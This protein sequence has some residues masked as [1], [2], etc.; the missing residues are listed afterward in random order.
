MFPGIMLQNAV[1]WRWSDVNPPIICPL[2]ALVPHQML[3]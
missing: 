1:Y 2:V 3:N